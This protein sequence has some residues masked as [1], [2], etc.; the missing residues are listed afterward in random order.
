MMKKIGIALSLVALAGCTTTSQPTQTQPRPQPR[1]PVVRTPAPDAVLDARSMCSAVSYEEDRNRLLWAAQELRD[2]IAVME[3]EA[4]PETLDRQSRRSPNAYG[5]PD[6]DSVS[7]TLYLV[8][9]FEAEL[10]GS[11]DAVVQNCRVY[12][13]CMMR[14]NYSEASCSRSADMWEASQVRFHQ[15]ADRM[16][17]V[18]ERVALNCRTCGT[19]RS[20]GSTS[21]G[22]TESGSDRRLGGYSTGG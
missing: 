2:N 3:A 6:P 12:N 21:S 13:Q 15:L 17:E 10:D 8:A 20:S 5:G 22:S 16:S 18:R 14:N 19:P 4:E 11:Y 9:Q 1:P 7:S